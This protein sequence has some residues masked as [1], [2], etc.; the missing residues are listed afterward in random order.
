[1]ELTG[2]EQRSLATQPTESAE[3]YERYLRGRY[4]WNKRGEEHLRT[5]IENFERAI[6]IDPNFALAY[7][8]IAATHNV[9]GDLGFVRSVEAYPAARAA[10]LKALE[11]DPNLAEAHTTLAMIT[12]QFDWKWE[13]ADRAFRRAIELNP[14]YPT[15]HQWY[16]EYLSAMGRSDEALREIDIALG[17]DPMS[18]IVNHVKGEILY[19]ADRNEEAIA[20]FRR[21]QEM[22]PSFL[23]AQILIVESMTVAGREEE[24][25]P[26][27]EKMAAQFGIDRDLLPQVRPAWETDGVKGL[28]AWWLDALEKMSRESFVHPVYPTMT[29]AQLGNNDEAIA[30]LEEAYDQELRLKNTILII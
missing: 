21:V 3:A 8:G 2:E 24:L 13:E 20:V 16:A 1:M 18:L 10:A 12:F 6:E 30:L 19:M 23:H 14:N 5:S 28:W 25:V 27:F 11:L 29:H 9:L 15:A 22:E 7:A 4:H 17:L 26:E